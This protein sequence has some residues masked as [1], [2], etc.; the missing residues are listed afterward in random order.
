MLHET[1]K[2][3]FREVLHAFFLVESLVEGKSLLENMHKQQGKLPAS[4]PK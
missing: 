4:L 1:G 3:K 2:N